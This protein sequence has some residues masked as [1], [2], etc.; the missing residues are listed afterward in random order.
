[1]TRERLDSLG[2]WRAIVAEAP[3]T[4]TEQFGPDGANDEVAAAIEHLH[5]RATALVA[6]ESPAR[7]LARHLGRTMPIV[8][9]GGATGLAAAI[10][11]KAAC[12]LH[13]KLPAFANEI[14]AVTHDEICGWGQNGDVTRQV[15]SLVLLRHSGESPA[16]AAAFDVVAD[17]CDEIVADVHTVVAGGPNPLAE[18]C[19]LV[20]FGD[21]VALELAAIAGID[22]GPT[23]ILDRFG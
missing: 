4:L 2:M 6:D 19:D 15:F 23:P 1:M 22:P 9:G 13:A 20:L 12:N 8:Y 7:R 21:V 18:L 5:S 10:R 17:I 3:A 16:E 11:W 14:I